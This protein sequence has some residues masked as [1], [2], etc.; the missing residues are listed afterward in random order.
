MHRVNIRISQWFKW[1]RPT[2]GLRFPLRLRSIL[3]VSIRYVISLCYCHLHLPA[4]P[5][6]LYKKTHR[7]AAQLPH[8]LFT[9][10]T[11]TLWLTLSLS[12]TLSFSPFLNTHPLAIPLSSLPLSPVTCPHCLSLSL[13]LS[14]SLFLWVCLS[15]FLPRVTADNQ[16]TDCLYE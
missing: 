3:S 16:L 8:H 10:T 9:D 6:W 7:W 15:L 4:W 12:L 11:H 1:L 2:L 13:S 14:R 5:L